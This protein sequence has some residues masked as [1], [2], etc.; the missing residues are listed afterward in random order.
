MC[1]VHKVGR[2]SLGGSF[3]Q[4][5]DDNSFFQ[6]CGISVAIEGSEDMDMNINGVENYS[7]ESDNEGNDEV[8]EEEPFADL[9]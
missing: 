7:V 4:Y 5:R 2:D 8:T 6:K 1:A 9:D 3:L